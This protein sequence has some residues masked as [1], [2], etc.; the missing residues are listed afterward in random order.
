MPFL[1]GILG[2]NSQGIKIMTL[3]EWIQTGLKHEMLRFF[4][5]TF[6]HFLQ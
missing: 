5:F 2:E 4:C 1:K 3:K 6:S